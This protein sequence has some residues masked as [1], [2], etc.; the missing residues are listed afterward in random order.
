MR[1]HLLSA[2]LLWASLRTLCFFTAE[3]PRVATARGTRTWRTAAAAAPP[4]PTPKA[5]V[6]YR[7]LTKINV[8]V[9]PEVLGLDMA[10]DKTLVGT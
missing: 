1:S 9:S 10:E 3:R 2:A 8:R 4:R 6:Y 7:A 5:P